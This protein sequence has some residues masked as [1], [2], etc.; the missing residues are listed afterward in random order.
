MKL[1]F[2]DRR[3]L[4]VFEPHTFSWRNR[5]LLSWYDTAFVGAAKVYIFEPPHDGKETQLSAQEIAGRVRKSGTD[6]VA[7]ESPEK[8]LTL[9]GKDME[10]H[11][12]ILLSSSGAMGGLIESI[13]KLAEQK[14]P[15]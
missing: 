2:P 5:D 4:V 14:F 11:D 7:V 1:H 9:L 10:A 15:K 3:L 13:P 6:A 8:T 12:D